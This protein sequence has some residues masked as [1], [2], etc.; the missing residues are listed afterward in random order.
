[1]NE[2]DLSELWQAYDALR[3]TRSPDPIHLVEEAARRGITVTV[4]DIRHLAWNR[5][6]EF[7]FGIVPSEALVNFFVS[8]GAALSP[9]T[10]LDPWAEF[11]QI[12][13]PTAR[14]QMVSDAYA[15]TPNHG[16]ADLGRRL[17]EGL[18]I[19]WEVGDPLVTMEDVGTINLIVGCP[20]FSYRREPAEVSI[21][22]V[23]F[24]ED[25]G[26]QIVAKAC[27]EHLSSAGTAAVVL[28]PSFAFRETGLR[29]QLQHLGLCLAGLLHVPPRFFSGTDIDSYVAIITRK[30]YDDMFVGEIGANDDHNKTLIK[31]LLDR[32]ET[33]ELSLGQLR[34][35]GEFL[36]YQQID[37]ERRVS[38]LAQRIGGAPAILSDIAFEINFPGGSDPLVERDNAIY[39][40]VAGSARVRTGLDE[41]PSRSKNYVQ[42]VLDPEKALA[43]YLA[44]YFNSPVGRATLDS[45]RTG[46][47]IQRISKEALPLCEV[48]L[49]HLETQIKCIETDAKAENLISELSALKNRIWDEPR[50]IAKTAKRLAQV[51][52]DDSILSWLETLPFPLA[53]VLWAG[54][55]AGDDFKERYE[56]LLHFFEA[57]AEFYGI[58]LWSATTSAPALRDDPSY[59]IS[60][61]QPFKNSFDRSTFGA[62]VEMVG[63]VSKFC[64]PLVSKPDG[65]ER[66]TGAFGTADRE[67]LAS[68]FSPGIVEQIQAAN[69]IR[70]RT[71]HG[72]ALGDEEAARRCVQLERVVASLRTAVGDMWSAIP[73]LK[74]GRAGFRGGV[75]QYDAERIMG[76]SQI[77]EHVKVSTSRPLEEGRLFLLANDSTA[78][79]ALAPLVI[80]GPSPQ[81]AN[82]A[83]YFY[84][85]VDGDDLLFISYHFSP[86][87]EILSTDPSARDVLRSLIEATRSPESK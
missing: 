28:P 56:H 24:R 27:A 68:L 6:R 64:R 54:F 30:T 55:A 73:L 76:R 74:A 17:S 83:A 2:S 19:R 77:F 7:S 71:A 13:V 1:M 50:A 69:R 39:M 23:R 38:L 18:P 86:E 22:G 60:P 46:T 59:P 4:D 65:K 14:N 75:Y 62:W 42:V 81:K 61:A 52:R 35:Q 34:K 45:M 31:N 78:P 67:V 47:T 58:V 25:Y 51:N 36:T 43:S 33:R 70:N 72:G 85:K 44:A 21:R 87:A 49:V 15:L 66:L 82:N 8:L 9:N 26:N 10:V 32:K 16:T 57:V 84:N 11:G 80:V 40:P 53:S 41:V 29:P 5:S 79:V 12:I 37:A 20:P 3:G 63:R 48:Y